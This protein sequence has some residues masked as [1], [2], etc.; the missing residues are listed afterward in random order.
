MGELGFA[1]GDED[2]PAEHTVQDGESHEGGGRGERP[3]DAH[4]HGESRPHVEADAEQAHGLARVQRCEG[5]GDAD[6]DGREERD[7]EKSEDRRDRD[8][9]NA[10]PHDRVGELRP[11]HAEESAE[12]GARRAADA[13]RR[14]LQTVEAVDAG[15]LEPRGRV[16]RVD[17]HVEQQQADA[18]KGHQAQS[19]PQQG[20]QHGEDGGTDHAERGELRERS[21]DHRRSGRPASGW[22]V[23]SGHVDNGTTGPRR[24]ASEGSG[25]PTGGYPPFAAPLSGLT[26]TRTGARWAQARAGVRRPRRQQSPRARRRRSRNRS[27]CR[28]RRS[29]RP[30]PARRTCG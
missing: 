29:D 21:G 25:D 30:S 24:R 11:D 12:S 4:G 19:D 20:E 26:P 23:G 3:D 8:A 17:E 5:A 18:E 2:R 16:H 10:A 15:V 13:D 9:G 7:D 14:Q 1:G 22:G 28:R 27:S 6:D